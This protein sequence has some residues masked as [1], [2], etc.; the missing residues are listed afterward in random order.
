MSMIPRDALGKITY[1]GKSLHEVIKGIMASG[2]KVKATIV[3]G[4]LVLDIAQQIEIPLG[5]DPA[6]N[7]L[8]DKAEKALDQ[9]VPHTPAKQGDSYVEPDSFGTAS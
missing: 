4:N 8:V 3:E 5:L 6:L 1:A 7:H 2:F 9:G